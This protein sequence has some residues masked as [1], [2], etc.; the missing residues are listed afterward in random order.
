MLNVGVVS[1]NKLAPLVVERLTELGAVIQA[2]SAPDPRQ[3]RDS[4]ILVG[5]A[6]RSLP[7]S[8][9]DLVLSVADGTGL[10]CPR[11][12]PDVVLTETDP[13]V[14]RSAVDQLWESRLLP[15][16]R[17]KAA[18]RPK[19][20]KGPA[21]MSPPDPAWPATAARTAE[22]ILRTSPL[23][24]RVDHIGSTSIPGLPAK[25]VIDLQVGVANVSHLDQV[26]AHLD[27]AGYRAVPGKWWDA[28]TSYQPEPEQWAKHLHVNSDP[29]QHVNIHVRVIGSA[30]WFFTLSFRDWM[31][32]DAGHVRRYA[33]EKQRIASKYANDVNALNYA[34]EKKLWFR[35]YVE[36]QLYAWVDANGWRPEKHSTSQPAECAKA[37][38]NPNTVTAPELSPAA[39]RLPF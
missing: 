25:N 39:T 9:F 22:R 17:N 38:V 31:R 21:V 13:T 23:I 26:S 12:S 4:R 34:A 32:A 3:E 37:E 7:T 2:R 28:P 33:A 30:G 6:D 1:G 24:V 11:H 19:H 29:A 16:S 8:N 15:F 36:P 5:C 20:R 27:V 14:L 35:D 10:C 18:P